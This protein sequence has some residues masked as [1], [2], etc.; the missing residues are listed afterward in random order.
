[1]K[2]I[3]N[4]VIP[5]ELERKGVRCRSA[6]GDDLDV[7]WAGHPDWFFRIS[8]FSIPWLK[9]PWVP[10]HVLSERHRDAARADRDASC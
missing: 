5:D 2:R 6:S 1:M 9:H 4:R 8:K 10:E 7:E 3:Y